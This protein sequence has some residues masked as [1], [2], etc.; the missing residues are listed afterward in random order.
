MDP[1][2]LLRGIRSARRISQ[3]ELAQLAELPR[4]TVDRIEA[5][6]VAPRFATMVRLLAATGYRF[7][8]QDSHGRFVSL[9]DDDGDRDRDRGGRR[10]PAH[11]ESGRTP[12]YFEQSNRSWWGWHCIAWPFTDDWVPE[13]TYW[14]RRPPPTLEQWPMHMRN[15]EQGRV[16]DDA[17]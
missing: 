2:E 13:H 4:S 17:T 10:F 5:G 12:G 1:G 8:L 16:W 15:D 6:A 14:R 11:L 9:T 3:R 7:A